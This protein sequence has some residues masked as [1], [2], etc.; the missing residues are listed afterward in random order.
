[1][2]V[3]LLRGIQPEGKGP[4]GR[5]R[6]LTLGPHGVFTPEEARRRAARLLADIRDGGEPSE[7]RHDPSKSPTMRKLAERDTEKHA[8][9][10]KKRSSVGGVILSVLGTWFQA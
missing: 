4:S 9:V 1:M 3:G 10:K 2:G 6:W 7:E 8:W 5:T